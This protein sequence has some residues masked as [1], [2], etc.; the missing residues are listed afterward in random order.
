MSE[1]QPPKFKPVNKAPTYSSP[2]ELFYKLSGRAKTHGYLRGPQQDVLREYAEKAVEIS[3]LAFELPTGTG[4]TAVGLLIAEWQRLSGKR[5]AYLSLTNQLAGQVL[6]ESKRL[7]IAAADLRGGKATRDAAE[8]GRY[9]TR[10]A[11]GITTYSNLFNIKPVLQDPDVIVLDD[12]HGGEQYVTSTWTV[13]ASKMEE[14]ALYHSLLAALG[15]GLSESQRWSLQNRS[16]LIRTHLPDVHQHPECFT[17]AAAVLDGTNVDSAKFAWA[18]IKHQL[19]ACLFIVSSYEIIIRPLIPPTHTHQPF[20]AAKQRLYLSATLGGESDLQRAYGVKKLGMLRAKSTQWGRRYVFVPGVYAAPADAD[21]ILARVW[22][23]LKTRRAVLLSPSDR[24]LTETFGRLEKAMTKKP[25]RIG[26][27]EITNSI[28]SF[29]KG[30]DVVLG[31]SGRYDGLD[32]PDDQ[33]RVLILAESPEAVN[34]LERHLS[35]TWKMGPVLKKRER[36]RLIQGMGRC[37]RN[38]TDFAVIFWLGQSLIDAANDQNL[39]GVMPPEL[40]A[41]ITWGVQQSEFAAKHPKQLIGMILSL[42]ENE[43]YR[44]DADQAIETIQSQHVEA[45]PKDYDEAGRREVDFGIAMWDGNYQ[46]ALTVARG[47]ADHLVSPELAGYRAWWWF[48]ASV[49]ASLAGEKK[50]ELD[51]LRRAASCGVNGGWLNHLIKSRG[52][53]TQG[54]TG[55]EPEPNAEGLWNVL[56]H[57]GW[58]GPG[59]EKNLQDMLGFLQTPYH[60]HFHQ[61]LDYLGRCYGAEVTR[62]TEQGAPDVVW[63]FSNDVHI[64]FEAKTEKQSSGLS[65]KDLLE[66]KGH[67]DWVKGRLCQNP[68]T[69]EIGVVVVAES[70]KIHPAGEMFG[71]GLLYAAPEHV[72]AVATSAIEAIRKLRLAFSGREFAE[73]STEFSATIKNVHLDLPALRKVMLSERLKKK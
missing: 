26:A 38:A 36:T 23:E 60:A 14:P 50:S 25:K 29:I 19:H 48:L 24:V 10:T 17:N 20:A 21:W 35:Q 66:A 67:V 56:V 30:N 7:G 31:L 8:E 59:F 72:L 63:S 45:M 62:I 61:G 11:L 69:A 1:F 6:E 58:A 37:T 28:D 49:A 73:A 68:D 9:R 2:E 71:E 55:Q 13:I 18:L 40:A 65:K 64:A 47:I 52:Q 39:L 4:K 16:S 34:L 12:A 27:A 53:A 41:E 32:L 5:V 70:P 3:D 22:D 42:I 46:H 54:K 57:W 43:D 44:K 15:P 33:C 51:C